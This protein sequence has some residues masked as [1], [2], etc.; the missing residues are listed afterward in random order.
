VRDAAHQERA[1]TIDFLGI[2]L[3]TVCVGSL[4]WMLERGERYDWFESRFVTALAVTSVVAGI[5][6]V[7][8]ELTAEDPVID[9]RVLR[10]RQLAAGVTFAA[11]LGLALYGSVFVLPVFLQSLHGFTAWQTGKVILPGALASAFMMAIVGRNANRL[12]ARYTIT[13][14]AGLFLLSMWQLSH[15]T[16]ES[17]ADDMFWPLILRGLGLGLIFVP[18]TNASMAELPVQKLAQGTGLYNLTRQLGGSLGIAIMATLLSRFT[19]SQKA[20]LAEH[21]ST[22]DPA[23]LDRLTTLTR[24]MM[25]RGMDA[26]TAKQQ[27]LAIIDRQIGAQASVL[28][29]SRIYLLSGILLVCALPLLALWKTGRSR[30]DVGP[31]H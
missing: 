20:R 21:V 28:A 30:M 7:W 2:A 16:L 9:F 15:L 19:Q 11:F 29:F 17:G 4:Q 25:A 5:A 24:G 8:R 27:A 22:Y 31:A 6:L 10:S 23:T 18:L 14:G 26:I 12:D 1:E 3:L 13:I